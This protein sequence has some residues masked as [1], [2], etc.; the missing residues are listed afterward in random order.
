MLPTVAK[1]TQSYPQLMVTMVCALPG[2]LGP[3]KPQ[4]WGYRSCP[5][6]RS[7][8]NLDHTMDEPLV[9]WTNSRVHSHQN[10]PKL[11]KEGPKSFLFYDFPHFYLPVPGFLTDLLDLHILRH[12]LLDTAQSNMKDSETQIVSTMIFRAQP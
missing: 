12:L 6:D 9:A 2:P 8:P 7:L 1:G 11:G 5:L 3:P 4:Y 10:I